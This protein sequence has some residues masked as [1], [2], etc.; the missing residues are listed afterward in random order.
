MQKIYREGLNRFQYWTYSDGQKYQLNE[1]TVK[2]MV[3]RKQAIIIVC[4]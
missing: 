4:E 2:R 3:S 1:K